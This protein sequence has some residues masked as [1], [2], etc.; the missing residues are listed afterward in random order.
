MS[1]VEHDQAAQ[2][3]LELIR[4]RAEALAE[5][6]RSDYKHLAYLAGAKAVMDWLNDTT[7]ETAPTDQTEPP[8]R[9]LVGLESPYQQPPA[10]QPSRGIEIASLADDQPVSKQVFYL[11][12]RTVSAANGSTLSFTPLTAYAQDLYHRRADTSQRQST[13]IYIKR[14]DWTGGDQGPANEVALVDAATLPA[15]SANRTAEDL[16][17]FGARID[18]LGRSLALSLPVP[19][20]EGVEVDVQ[21]KLVAG[22]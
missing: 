1:A 20:I 19:A 9:A 14:H 12:R 5:P 17:E 4:S 3:W 16:E 18:L 2:T 13:E 7:A 10:R 21:L 8:D 15:R 22:A 11:G 6:A